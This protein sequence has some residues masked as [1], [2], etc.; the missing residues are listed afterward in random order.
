MSAPELKFLRNEAGETEGLS[1]GGV[2]TFRHAPYASCAREAGQNSR[3][4]K[5]GDTV[6][7]TFNVSYVASSEFPAYDALSSAISCCKIQAHGDK[8]KEFF[9]NASQ[10]LE[11]E[12]IP[13][14]EISDF[15]TT[16][17]TGPADEEGTPFHSL[18]KASGISAK[19]TEEAG[20]SFGIGKNATFA[21][22]DLQTVFYSTIYRK[23]DVDNFAFQGK[24][25][26]ISHTSA[27]G[28]KLRSTGYW[29]ETA[30]FVAVTDPHF[31]PE[32]MRRTEVGTSIFCMGFRADDDWA[33]SMVYPLVAN[34]FGAVHD[35][36][37][38]FEVDSGGYQ[39][40][41]NTLEGLFAN[42][43][44]VDAAKRAGH[45]SELR[46]SEQLYRCLVSSHAEEHA[47]DVPE[48]GE[49]SIRV[50]IEEGMPRRVGFMRNGMLIT[51]NLRNF[52][53]PLAH[54]RGSRD[55]IVL[56]QP[57]DNEAKVL[58]RKLENPAHDSFSAERL[59]S[60]EQR[61][62]AS[63]AL[64]RFG[65][66]LREIIKSTTGVEHEGS[67]VLDELG[68]FFSDAGSAE[69]NGHP[70]PEHDPERYTYS[71]TRRKPAT[72][73]A[74]SPTD[75][76]GGGSAGRG[77]GAGGDRGGSGSETGSG[78]DGRGT[79]GYREA[80]SLQDVRNTFPRDTS[81]AGFSRVLHF[82][83]ELT[84]VLDLSVE[85][86]GVN[87]LEGLT[88]TATDRGSINAGSLEVPVREGERVTV[89]VSFDT[90]YD[91]PIELTA[92]ASTQAG[93]T[94]E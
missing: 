75:G 35:E 32:W 50:L 55:F 36:E 94:A 19:S 73:N 70:N 24:V 9:E 76:S 66:Q 63:R 53:H 30:G 6:R 2:E 91:G 54:F 16:G 31:V 5:D 85:A 69:T 80:V 20:G 43:S 33:A 61:K 41:R 67:V 90:P 10:V 59:P 58:L 78:S 13:V 64:K 57:K 65:K 21:V 1:D 39:I 72:K 82:T 45:I 8:E 44:V 3:D 15:S 40:N 68:K 47:V 27:D 92:A 12:K 51:D 71:A 84:G 93:E 52:G 25:K 14:L 34:F 7:M 46:F 18:V 22:S 26:L 11:A 56:V 17:L 42:A 62:S 28:K 48:L 4:A 38:S 86:T 89:S 23:N 60:P 83:P 88:I 87:S 79:R 29:G 74:P 37:M 77:A 81:G 49:M